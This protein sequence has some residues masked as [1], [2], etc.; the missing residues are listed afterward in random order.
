MGLTRASVKNHGKDIY[1]D[2]SI[3]KNLLTISLFS[4]LLLSYFI[5]PVTLNVVDHTRMI[6][7]SM[8]RKGDKRAE[9]NAASWRTR[10]PNHDARRYLK[11]TRGRL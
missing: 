4:L 9:S 3:I 8:Q 2:N 7:V 10:A 6:E 1:L 5:C 11:N